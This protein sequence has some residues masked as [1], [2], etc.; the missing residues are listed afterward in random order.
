MSYTTI[1]DASSEPLRNWWFPAIGLLFIVMI[2]RQSSDPTKVGARLAD[3]PALQKFILAFAVVWTVI[4]ALIVGTDNYKAAKALRTGDYKVA[5]GR[6]ENFIAV[7]SYGKGDESFDVE[8]VHFAYSGYIITAGYNTYASHGG[9]IRAGLPVRIA[10]KE[11]EI[12]RLEVA[13]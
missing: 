10:Y 5:E 4:A 8:G 6:V 3:R 2:L 1:F 12:L 9:A 7:P 13:R 11:G